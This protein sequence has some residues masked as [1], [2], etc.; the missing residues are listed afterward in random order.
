M[1]NLYNSLTTEGNPPVEVFGV[2]ATDVSSG[3]SSKAKTFIGALL[4]M[5]FFVVGGWSNAQAQLV[6]TLSVTDSIDCFGGTGELTVNANDP[7]GTAINPY[8]I[9]W[10]DGVTNTFSVAPG[11]STNVRSGLTAGTYSITVTDDNGAGALSGTATVNLVEPAELLVASSAST[12]VNCNAGSDG[13]AAIEITGGSAPYTY[14]WS[15]GVT[16]V[17]SDLTDT[18]TGLT[19]GSY[20]VTVTDDNGCGP[21]TQSYTINQPALALSGT[22]VGTDVTC[23]GDADGSVDLT[24]VGGTTPYSFSWNTGATTEDISGLSGGTYSVTITDANGCTAT[25]SAAVVEPAVLTDGLTTTDVQCNGDA[26]GTYAFSPAGGTGG[27]TY[28]VTGPGGPYTTVSQTGLDVGSYNYTVTDANSC[29][30][31]GS[32]SISEPPV[33]A[34]TFDSQ[35]D[36]LCN[37][38]STGAIN[39]TVTGG[40]SPY[41][42]DWNT[43]AYTT[44]DLSGI[45]A[46]T[47]DLEVTDDNG[48]TVTLATVTITEPTAVSVTPNITDVDCFGDADGEI[49]FT[50]SGGVAPYDVT[51]Q[52]NGTLVVATDGGAQTF[53]GLNGGTYGYTVTDD[54]GCVTTGSE[55]VVE[56]VAALAATST[57]TEVTCFGDADGSIDV[58]VTGGTTPYTFA[59]SDG[60][61]TT[62]DRTG[63]SGG[64]YTVTITDDNSCTTTLSVTIDEPAAAVSVTGTETDASCFGFSDG[65]I[66]ITPAGGRSPYTFNWSTGETT[67]D[68]SGLIAGSYDVTVTDDSGCVVV[69]TYTINEPTQITSSIVSTTPVSCFGL[70]DGE[71]EFQVDGGGVANYDISLGGTT[72]FNVPATTPVT[73]VGLGAGTYQIDVTD[74]SGC[75]HQN[76]VTITQPSQI[77]LLDTTITNVTCVGDADG[78]V[79]IT[80]TGGTPPYTYAWS[81]GD[82]TQD[83]SGVAAGAYS[84]TITDASSCTASFGPFSV[85]EPA[86]ALAV[87]LND[88]NVVCNGDANGYISAVVTGGWNTSTPYTYNWNTG[89]TTDSIGGLAPGSYTVTVTDS[90]G[91]VVT[92]STTITEPAPLVVTVDAGNTNDVT[93]HLGSDGAVGINITGGRS[94]TTTPPSGPYLITWSNGVSNT[95]TQSGLTAGTYDVTVEDASGCTETLS[96]VVNEPDPWDVT[97][98]IDSVSCN[99]LSDGAIDITVVG[100][101]TPPYTFLW[102]NTATTEDISGLTQGNYTVTITDING[103]DTSITYTV[104]EPNVLTATITETNVLCFGD[105]TGAITLD[106]TGGNGGGTFNWVGTDYLSNPFTASTQNLSGLLAGTY[107]VTVT[108][109][110][111]CTATASV[112]ITQPAADWTVTETGN[113]V[114]CNG[115]ATG[116]ID[117][118]VSG[119]TAPYTLDYTGT[120]AGTASI[121]TDGGSVNIGG[122]VAGTYD[123]TVTDDNGC[124]FVIPTVTINEPAPL[125]STDAVTDV[126]CNGANDGEY[127]I[128]V[129]GGVAPYGL[130]ITGGATGSIATDGGTFTFTGLAPGTYSVDVLDDNGCAYTSSS[131]VINEPAPLTLVADVDSACNSTPTGQIELTITGGN[132][133]YTV[134]WSTTDVANVATDGGS[135]TLTGLAAGTYDVTVVD[136]LGC[137]ETASYVVDEP[138]DPIS[139][140]NFVNNDVSCYGGSDGSILTQGTTGGVS[141]YTYAWSGPSGFTSNTKDIFGLVAGLYDLTITD[142]IGCERVYLN[143]TVD[144][145]DSLSQVGSSVTD[146]TCFGFADGIVNLTVTGGTP[147]YTYAWSNGAATQDLNGV[148]AGTYTVT[149]TDDNLCTLVKSFT[150]D[151]PAPLTISNGIGTD[152][153]LTCKGDS[154]GIIDINVSGGTMPYAYAWSSG[155]TT[156][157]IS[158]L[159][160]GTYTVTVTDANSCVETQT[161]NVLEPALPLA[162]DSLTQDSVSCFGLSDGSVSAFVSGGW[163]S[164][165]YQWD[166]AGASTTA[167][168]TGLPAGTYNVTVTDLEGCTVTGTVTVLEPT[169]LTASAV[170]DQNVS[171]N[172][173]NDGAATVTAGGGTPSYTYLWD[174]SETTASATMLDAGVHTV[175]VTDANGCTATASVTITEPAVLTA[176][177]IVTDVTCKGDTDGS[178]DITPTGGT[179][180]YSFLWST[181]STNEDLTG[182]GAG[183]YTVTITDANNCVFVLTET[184]DEPALPLAIDNISSTDVSCNGGNDGSATVNVSGGWGSYTYAWSNSVTTAT[185]SGLTAG[186]YS[187]TVTDLNGCEVASSVTINEPPV[188]VGT[189]DSV[190]PVTCNGAAD[191]II[192]YN[193]AGGTAPYVVVWSN[194]VTDNIAASGDTAQLVGLNAQVYTATVTDANGCVTTITQSL[195]NPALLSISLDGELLGC[196]GANNGFA[197]VEITGGVAPY[198]VSWEK[199]GVF[200]YGTITVPGPAPLTN[201]ITNLTFG[202]YSVTVT[203][204]NGCT[205]ADTITLNDPTDP[206]ISISAIKGADCF[207]TATGEITIAI[208]DG[209]STSPYYVYWGTGVVDTIPALVND[210]GF[211]TLSG[212]TAGSYSVYVEDLYGCDD[213]L[214][215]TITEP[216]TLIATAVGMDVNTCFGDNTGMAYVDVVGGSG[217]YTYEWSTAET[218]DTIEDLFAGTYT[219]TVTDSLGCTDVSSVVIGQP[220]A[221]TVVDSVKNNFG[222]LTA[223]NGKVILDISGATPPYT[224]NWS[225]GMM[226]DSIVNLLAGV[227]GYTVTDANNCTVVSSAIVQDGVDPIILSITPNNPLCNGDMNGSIDVVVTGGN[228]PYY[229]YLEDDN[230][231]KIDTIALADSLITYDFSGYGAG[232]YHVR[233]TDAV[234]CSTIDTVSLIDNDPLIATVNSFSDVSCFGGNDGVID[235]TVTGGTGTYSYIWSG[236]A[237]NNTTAT[238]TG[239][240]A[241]SYAVTVTD[242]NNCVAFA[243]QSIAEP[244]ALSTSSTVTDA[245]CFGD[246][247][248]VIDLTVSGGTSPYSYIW[249]SGATTAVVSNLSAATYFVTVTDDNMC[250]IKDTVTV[251]QPDDL[252]F[253][254][255]NI[256]D[257]SCNGFGDGMI[258]LTIDGGTMPYSY[259]WSGAASTSTSASVSGLFAGAYSVT[260][261]DASGCTINNT[262][263]VNEPAVLTASIMG[264]DVTGCFGGFNGTADLTVAG[265]TM[266][267]AFAWSNGATTEDLNFLFAGTYSVTVTDGNGCTVTDNVTINQPAPIMANAVVNNV[268]CNGNNDGSISVTPNGGTAP[269]TYVW[270]TSETTSSINGLAPGNYTV[271]IDDFFGCDTTYSF[272]ITEPPVLAIALDTAIDVACFG[273][274]SGVIDVSVT[275]GTTPYSYLWTDATTDNN[276]WTTQDL[277]NVVAGTYTLVVT[278]NN[279]CVE[280]TTVTLTEP[281]QLIA[282]ID[283][284]G[285]VTCF[286]GSDGIV[287][288]SVSGGVGTYS[289][290]WSNGAT[291]QNVSNLMAG[292]FSVVITDD[293]GCTVTLDSTINQNDEIIITADSVDNILCNGASTGNIYISVTGGVGSYTYNWTSGGSTVATTQDLTNVPA[294]TYTGTVTDSLGC[295]VSATVTLTEP[296]ALALAETINDVSCFGFSDGEIAVVASGGVAPYSFLWAG[297]QTTGTITGLT[298][299][300]YTVTVT[301]A[302][303]C[304]IVDTY[305]VTQPAAPLSAGSLIVTDVYGCYGDQTGA[306]DLQIVGGTAPY[307]YL[308]S[309]GATTQ[310][311]SN[312]SAGGYQVTVN[313]ANGCVYTVG[314]LVEQPDLL[315][316]TI[317]NVTN[318]ACNGG[319]NASIDLVV[320]GG[321]TG[322]TPYQ[323]NWSNGA[324]TQDISGVGAGTYY[325]TVTDV[326]GCTA[327]DSVTITQPAVLDVT[328]D[329]IDNVTCFGTATGGVDATITGGTAPYTISWTG[330]ITASTEDLN[331]VPAGTYVITVTDACGDVVTQTV[332]ITEPAAGLTA[333][334]AT[335]NINCF[336][337]ANGVADLTVSGGT[338]PYSFLWNTGAVTEDLTAVAAGTY[339][340]V[341]TDA[342]GCTTSATAT[343]SQPSAPVSVSIMGTDVACQGDANGSADAMVTGGTAPYTFMWSNMATT[344]DISGLAAGTYTLT[345]TDANGCTANGSVVIDEP[346]VALTISNTVVTDATCNGGMDG[347]IDITVAG[348]VAPYTYSWNTGATTQ[349]LSGV[350][351]GNYTVVVT[352]ANGCSVTSTSIT[353]AEPAAIAVSA[354][355][356]DVNCFGGNTGAI[357]I[358]V[359][360]GQMPYTFSWSNGDVSEDITGLTAGSYTGVVTDANGCSVSAT[361]VVGQPAA[362]L[363]VTGVVSNISCFGS[364]D[365]AVDITVT[366]GTAPY[367]YSWSN[368]AATED[369]SGLA[370][371]SATVVVTDANGC[372]T[373]ASFTIT[374]PASALGVS[375][376]T[377]TDVLCNGGN[378]GAIDIT[379]TGGTAP[380]TFSWS[381]GAGSEDLTNLSAGSY[382]GTITDANGCQFVSPALVVDEP[383]SALALS[384]AVVTDVSCNGGNDGAV[385]ITVTGGTPPYTF[386]WNNGS[387]T[388]DLTNVPA[389]I[390][391]GTITDANGCSIVG[392]V[393]V[394][395]PTAIATSVSV[396]NIDCFGSSTGVV[397][398]TV[399]GGTAPYTYSWS[400]GDATQDLNGVAAGTYNVIITD[401]AG[402]TVNATATVTQA[403]ALAANII[404]NDV[405][406]FGGS[407]GSAVANVNGGTPPY[408]Y[409]WSSGQ[410]TQNVSGLSAGNVSVTITDANG[411]TTTSTAVISEPA[412]LVVDAQSVTNSG[413]ATA[414]VTGGTAPYSYFWNTTPAQLTQTAIGLASG[415]YTV[416]VTDANGCT[417]TDTVNVV[418]VGVVEYTFGENIELYPNPASNNVTV[419]YLFSTSVDLNTVIYNS[420]GQVVYNETEYNTTSNT[421]TIDVADLSDGVYYVVF[422]D[423]NYTETK[424][425]VIQK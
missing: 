27:Y 246:M 343:V 244:M 37:G 399:T 267:Y 401:A 384:G 193:V 169:L 114:L 389:G 202:T 104:D 29:T 203:D 44:E 144:E 425:L 419:E 382:V 23:N 346:A 407:T 190:K 306:I 63:L 73:F 116:S 377:I 397:D 245:T 381:N 360:G 79:N 60:P 308:W 170:V 309:N 341:I 403:P 254:N 32:F 249:S 299:G 106:T 250:E 314:V 240:I 318:V 421:I 379:V 102:S 210:T 387:I 269:Y 324:N 62:E 113:D 415:T 122:L 402:C 88:S 262:Y 337:A 208:T 130:T 220:T 358:T 118:T 165:T 22:T 263:T 43:G 370:S 3:R 338:A 109:I 121:A 100:G 357:D 71:V 375:N 112:V 268:T 417:A 119:N 227:Y 82:A 163:G 217:T 11:V 41:T 298:P 331:G 180:P 81:N 285:T 248:G 173:G 349:D 272:V 61:A 34:V 153:I 209:D 373:S 141:P 395:Q 148:V 230:N 206:Q 146:V 70:T 226:G 129:T 241:G 139:V 133:G 356:T 300:S 376:V 56:P 7:S 80:P 51:L 243:N 105:A 286:G 316:A 17:S 233:A 294:G 363:A 30:V 76:F 54:N 181:T 47:Y 273:D 319:T 271:K 95:P 362:A 85:I 287:D 192:Y 422:S 98:V 231:V 99:G 215:F 162:I 416:Q 55:T 14:V 187:V 143:V 66:D 297:G 140:G 312:L 292:N 372:S 289:Y 13:T 229:I 1:S 16:T 188:L 260:V 257:V 344:E 265:G 39:V 59:W 247:D 45:P 31:T 277:N 408:T 279:N 182:V 302:N 198:Q 418:N 295:S 20:G 175:T 72:F 222:C 368:G 86:A 334:I 171:C 158:G 365:G 69:D 145:P 154:D 174:N 199:Q 50:V 178:I 275:G 152:L 97:A 340:V 25:A 205:L 291:T 149:I 278:D 293:N 115:D 364:T 211:S 333:S 405:N 228:A 18:I 10:S 124:T 87:T 378:T 201:S 237:S 94:F 9:V 252:I 110:N 255:V 214:N 288:I 351:A 369:V 172:G 253:D 305:N 84:L 186:T 242:G 89:A 107:S 414:V 281:T 132:P 128:T 412:Q 176:T 5:A 185:N 234:G 411:C 322:S 83:I 68:I 307:S 345:V 235:L 328:I 276:T 189:V 131:L 388:E 270:S 48:C 313:D 49:E 195:V 93:C 92:A 101:N 350:A 46:G 8:F 410:N 42:Y 212:L 6:V 36:V 200:T 423:G 138:L 2:R 151:Q 282:S 335:T 35:T 394:T 342:N 19:A 371:G 353:V 142:A 111:G 207:G 261:T 236:A 420:V 78:A 108:D 196:P 296:A 393:T 117:V 183:T 251:G 323:Y 77:D 259:I 159:V 197:D 179:T 219:V 21:I 283:T 75:T 332:T 385:D 380:Y 67:E 238:A 374:Q 367:T 326:N 327:I 57:Q 320:T 26:D 166:D 167:T 134:T 24:V 58:T 284:V 404:A 40:T 136:A 91:C 194:G 38:E 221:L 392:S 354:S 96:F 184:V 224:V 168:V 135:T 127:E 366:G 325:V 150:V 223:G 126:T 123:I 125:A 311:I 409:A 347:M 161:Y 304:D 315:V 310:D 147:P 398:L 406:C 303:G 321:T 301:D 156:Q 90:L 4:M 15:N 225:N 216:D 391:T 103:C 348:G 160:A 329:N 386:S 424:R 28:N 390:Y 400:N 64:S 339:T 280:T 330:N 264:T 65:S 336:G 120:S 164:Y 266:P 213:T 218:T 317:S 355:V 177:A 204:A 413:Q 52:G 53:T 256:T 290:L 361:V 352:D 396:T 137:T 359:T 157:D 383:V 12:D 258:D 33:L 232:F 74:A 274:A 239:L 191:G 155:Q